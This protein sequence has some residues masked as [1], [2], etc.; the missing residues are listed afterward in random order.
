M[1]T[2]LK[3]INN[4]PLL[5]REEEFEL[6]MRAKKGDMQAREKLIKA[7]CRF[8]ISIAKQF[9]NRG[10]PL[11]DLI[12]EGNIGLINGID[13]FEPEKGYHFISYGV[14][15]IR[16]AI[17]K[18]IAE[19]SRMIRLP[20]N[21]NA[22]YAQVVR[23]REK[24]ERDGFDATVEGIAAECNL[25][26]DDVKEILNFNKDI[27]SLDAPVNDDDASSFGEFIESGEAG[28][29]EETMD[30]V[31]KEQFE[32]ILSRFPERERKIITLRYG[33]LD[34]KPM[35][36]KQVGE[37]FNL[38]KERIRQLEKKTLSSLKNNGEVQEMKCYIA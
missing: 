13:K 36:L 31:L 34:N 14:W 38:T 33:L 8:V 25:S 6:A 37:V 3:E 35:S 23:S 10:L 28:P 22:Q 19:Q 32:R 17:M 4:V 24:L 20:M 7:N 15:W 29:E 2:Y 27:C 30:A 21:R 12:S 5:S 9:Q 26:E 16:Q 1:Q 18:A 11:E